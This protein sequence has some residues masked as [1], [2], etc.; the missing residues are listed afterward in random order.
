MNAGIFPTV[1]VCVCATQHTSSVCMSQS[2][3]PDRSLFFKLLFCK[4]INRDIPYSR[5]CNIKHETSPD[6]LFYLGKYTQ[7]NGTL[8]LQTKAMLQLFPQS[9]F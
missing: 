2:L 7:F 6:V 3:V 8:S 4:A 5:L 1:C 9:S